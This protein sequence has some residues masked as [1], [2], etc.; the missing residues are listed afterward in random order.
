MVAVAVAGRDLSVLGGCGDVVAA[1]VAV[2]GASAVD[3]LDQGQAQ[4]IDYHKAFDTTAMD[5]DR[6][7]ELERHSGGPSVGPQVR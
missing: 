4:C 5:Y 2:A 1:L 3:A 7:V 6:P